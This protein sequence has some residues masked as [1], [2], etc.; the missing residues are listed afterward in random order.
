MVKYFI[1]NV[2]YQWHD[3]PLSR[4]FTEFLEKDGDYYKEITYKSLD[5]KLRFF[6]R[7]FEELKRQGKVGTTNPRTMKPEDIHAFV[8]NRIK[9]KVKS[10]VILHDLSTLKT[11]LLSF[12]NNAVDE[13]KIK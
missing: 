3:I 9:N 13:Y 4:A 1:G 11:F 7:I 12:G 5:R 6:G 8:G 10:N 2:Y